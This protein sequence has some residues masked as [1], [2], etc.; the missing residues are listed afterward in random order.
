MEPVPSCHACQAAAGRRS[1]P[2]GA[3][4][5][6]ACAT[7]PGC[8]ANGYAWASVRG[9]VTSSTT[10]TSPLDA[11]V[12]ER[13][14]LPP[15]RRARTQVDLAP[16]IR[17]PRTSTRPSQR[18]KRRRRMRSRRQPVRHQAEPAGEEVRDGAGGPRL[19]PAGDGVGHRRRELRAREAGEQLGQPV[20]VGG[21]RRRRAA[22]RRRGRS[23]RRSR[24]RAARRR[25]S[26]CRAATPCR[27]GSRPGCRPPRPRAS[28]RMPQPENMRVVHHRVADRRRRAPGGTA[29]PHSR[30]PWLDASARARA[31]VG[32]EPIE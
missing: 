4:P 12:R 7:T 31:A 19:R 15:R 27:G 9:P 28:V 32:A 10:S 6:A 22:P 20:G 8:G 24:T 2:A 13:H 26:R 14:V 11:G 1:A 3:R 16:A 5:V 23:P 18:R 21:R 25:S 17:S 29:R 30:W